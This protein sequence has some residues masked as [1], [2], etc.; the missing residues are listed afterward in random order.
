MCCVWL[1]VSGLCEITAPPEQPRLG[2]HHVRSE[3]P[4]CRLV[5]HTVTPK[6]ARAQRPLSRRGETCMGES[7]VRLREDLPRCIQPSL[8][9]LSDG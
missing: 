5:S 2:F 9:D 7:G 8:Y 6:D 3:P 4:F 1:L